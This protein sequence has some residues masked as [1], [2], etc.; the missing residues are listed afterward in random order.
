MRNLAVIINGSLIAYNLE[1]II[2]SIFLYMTFI[3]K[4][5]QEYV[6]KRKSDNMYIQS[7]PF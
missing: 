1:S 3:F 6:F 7:I 2:A 4:L 5:P